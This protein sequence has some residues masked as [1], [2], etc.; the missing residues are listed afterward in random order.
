MAPGSDGRCSR[1]HR[2][3][4]D[5]ALLILGRGTAAPRSK[6]LLEPRGA[7]CGENAPKNVHP[8][9]E[10]RQHEH[11]D[12]ASGSAGTRIPS[13]KYQPTNARMDEGCR[14]HDARLQGDV[15]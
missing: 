14:T 15:E 12:D 1:R 8:M 6:K 2:H 5:A 3:G 9:I 13:A 7:L 4:D 10:L 11:I